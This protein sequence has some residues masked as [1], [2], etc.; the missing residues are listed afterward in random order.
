VSLA[1]S[2]MTLG[3][4]GAASGVA[5]AA[6]PEWCPDNPNLILGT[7]GTD[8]LNGTL[9]D[10]AILGFGSDDVLRGRLGEDTLR[11]GRGNDRLNGVES[12]FPE[13]DVLRGGP[14]VDVCVID[15]LDLALSCE[16]VIEVDPF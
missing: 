5:Q 14:G 1:V 12:L 9:C 7:A 8:V 11:G 4:V 16:V 10:D 6:V 13:F 3:T 15:V 2:A